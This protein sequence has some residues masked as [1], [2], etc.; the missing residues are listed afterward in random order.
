MVYKLVMLLELLQ[1][2]C[3]GLKMP[4][5]VKGKMQEKAD[6]CLKEAR[7]ALDAGYYVDAE[8]NHAGT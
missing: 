5:E 7:S 6:T 8:K 3:G 2:I 4:K 1:I